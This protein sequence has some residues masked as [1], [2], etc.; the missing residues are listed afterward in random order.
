MIDSDHEKSI[1]RN[2][3]VDVVLGIMAHQAQIK[4][5]KTAGYGLSIED[6][7]AKMANLS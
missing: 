1:T 7:V 2:R 6:F 5:T 3:N 4:L